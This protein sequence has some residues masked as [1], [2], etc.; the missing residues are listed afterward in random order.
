MN[1]NGSFLRW[2]TISINQLGFTSNLIFTVNLAIL[3]F[4]VSNTMDI[5]FI[6]KCEGKAFFTFGLIILIL[7]FLTGIIINLTRISDFRLTARAARLREKDESDSRLEKLR[8]TTKFLGKLTWIIFIVQL[9]SFGLGLISVFI[10]IA[11]LYSEKL[12]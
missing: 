11:I 7:S 2:Q 10:S 3:G 9:S 1:K 4:L 8:Q 6:L 12:F 5:N